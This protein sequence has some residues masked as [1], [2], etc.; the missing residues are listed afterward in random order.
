MLFKTLKIMIP[1]GYDTEMRK[2]E[3]CKLALL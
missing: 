2:I 3:Q 1:M